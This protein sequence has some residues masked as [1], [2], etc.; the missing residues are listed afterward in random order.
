MSHQIDYK[1]T[2]IV[3]QPTLDSIANMK[4]ELTKNAKSVTSTL[5]GGHH[6][7]IF[8]VLTAKEFVSI[9]GTVPVNRPVHPGPL[10]HI[11]AGA[12]AAQISAAERAHQEAINLFD[13]YTGVEIALL[14]QVEEAIEPIYLSPIINEQT[15]SLDRDLSAVLNFRF[16]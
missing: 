16:K 9:P 6:G 10:P 1:I 3:G 2:N 4:R 11:P 13:R 7:H 5:S 8:L 12:T 15:Q 14:A